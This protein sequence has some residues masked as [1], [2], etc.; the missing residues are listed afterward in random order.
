MQGA[1]RRGAGVRNGKTGDL[2][3]HSTPWVQLGGQPLTCETGSRHGVLTGA[4]DRYEV[5][6]THRHRND[7]DAGRGRHGNGAGY[8][9]DR[10]WKQ[11]R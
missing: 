7:G 6:A 3:A 9:R 5:P 10:I 2:D 1:G 4:F 11:R 8:A